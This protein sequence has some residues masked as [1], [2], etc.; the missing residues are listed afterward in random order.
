M[1][2]VLNISNQKGSKYNGKLFS[3]LL[4]I[5]EFLRRSQMTIQKI[6]LYVHIKLCSPETKNNP[7]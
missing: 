5:L 4:A 2:D 6:F 1:F 7:H 3:N